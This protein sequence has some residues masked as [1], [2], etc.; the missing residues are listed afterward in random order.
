MAVSVN[1]VIIYMKQTNNNLLYKRY[2][3]TI[4]APEEMIKKSNQNAKR[5]PTAQSAFYT[6]KKVCSCCSKALYH[7]TIL[8]DDVPYCKEC[9]LKLY[10][11]GHW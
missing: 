4:L 11:K 10:N 1:I 9:H 3:G 5:I 7:T 2:A 8:E 6:N